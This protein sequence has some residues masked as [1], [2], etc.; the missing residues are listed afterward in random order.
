[1]PFLF[2][3]SFPSKT[4]PGLE[5]P[6]AARSM[7]SMSL[8]L[9]LLDTEK[10]SVSSPLPHN[11]AKTGLSEPAAGL[12]SKRRTRPAGRKTQGASARSCTRRRKRTPHRR[13][14]PIAK[15]RALVA[16]WGA[17]G[18]GFFSMFCCIAAVLALAPL[19]F[20][21]LDRANAGVSIPA[22]HV[23]VHVPRP[24]TRSLNCNC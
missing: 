8:W 5:S 20:D 18:D 22:G 14:I 13:N 15:W 3:Q 24:S 19:A 11:Y 9:P 21:V 1:M 23:L 6:L 16:L 4:S 2:S 10:T 7:P 12:F 17:A